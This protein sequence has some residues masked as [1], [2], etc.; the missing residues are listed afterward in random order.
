MKTLK[1]NIEIKI[2]NEII[3][4]YIKENLKLKEEI[5]EKDK[6]IKIYN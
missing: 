5:K 6:I 2:G 1:K 3:K 4:K